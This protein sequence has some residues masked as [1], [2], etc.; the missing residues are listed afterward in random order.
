MIC[1]PPIEAISFVTVHCDNFALEK[2]N[3]VDLEEDEAK[4]WMGQLFLGRAGPLLERLLVVGVF[5]QFAYHTI[6]SV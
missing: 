4:Y 2:E 5:L 6:F 3:G 1:A